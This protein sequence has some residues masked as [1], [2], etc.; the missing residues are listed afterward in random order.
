MKI[1]I[2]PLPATVF[3]FGTFRIF[4]AFFDIVNDYEELEAHILHTDLH[5][6]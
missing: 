5:F 2:R 4:L 3:I 1:D 6:R